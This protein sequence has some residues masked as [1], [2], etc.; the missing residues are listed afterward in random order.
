MIS[1]FTI[2]NIC[3]DMFVT[4]AQKPPKQKNIKVPCEPYVS[5]NIDKK[6]FMSSLLYR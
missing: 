4:V 6:V 5:L 1:A 2:P 3:Y